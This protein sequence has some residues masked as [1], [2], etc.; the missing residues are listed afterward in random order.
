MLKARA[1]AG[2]HEKALGIARASL[3]TKQ[4]GGTLRVGWKSKYSAFKELRASKKRVISGLRS[5]EIYNNHTGENK[6]LFKRL[7]AGM[8]GS[9]RCYTQ[10]KR[11]LLYSERWR[12]GSDHRD[13]SGSIK[14][15][16][17]VLLKA[18]SGFHHQIF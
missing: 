15:R 14:C 10:L 9:W 2:E 16:P 5:L 6:G 11:H 1:R 13:L 7:R 4:H 17:Q 3:I 18:K 12:S 8:T